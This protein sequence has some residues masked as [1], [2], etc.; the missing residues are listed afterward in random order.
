MHDDGMCPYI[1]EWEQLS[2]EAR[3]MR[4]ALQRIADGVDHPYG[5]RDDTA[6]FYAAVKWAQ[7]IAEEGLG[8]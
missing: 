2:D 6:E 5:M 3:R 4:A 1:G 7:R 8:G